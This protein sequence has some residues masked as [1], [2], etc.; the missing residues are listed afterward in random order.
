MNRLKLFIP[1]IVVLMMFT[2]F[3]PLLMDKDRDATL[4]PSVMVGRTLPE[5]SLPSLHDPQK[6][7]THEDVLGETFLIN[8]WATWCPSCKFEHP[9][10]L[11]LAQEGINIYGLD[12]RDDADRALA[13][14]RDLGD[15]YKVTLFDP[16]GELVLDLGVYGA[17]ETYLVNAEGKILYRH[18]GVVDE[19][20]WNETLKPLYFSEETFSKDTVSGETFSSESVSNGINAIAPSSKDSSSK[21]SPS[22]ESNAN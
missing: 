13:W 22:T 7:Y 6:I 9:Y 1:V 18:V 12:Y 8:V 4:L 3:L 17:P 19:K 10:L 15:P 5:F 14:L 16:N 20:V 11:K 21:D 2:L